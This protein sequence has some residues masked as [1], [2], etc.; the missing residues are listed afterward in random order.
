MVR[1]EREKLGPMVEIDESFIGGAEK[2]RPGRGARTKSQVLLAVELGSGKNKVGRIRLFVIPNAGSDSLLPFIVKNVEQGSKVVTDGWQGYASLTKE[3]FLHITKV[4]KKGQ[5]TLPHVHL[6]FSLL[7]R[8]LDGTF[9]GATRKCYLDFYL[10]EFVF[11]FNRRK[12]KSRGKLF[13]R[14]M[15]QAVMTP[16]VTRQELRVKTH[17]FADGKPFQKFCD[18]L[19]IA[20]A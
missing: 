6:V 18:A 9:Q 13:R 12:S 1:A 16:P 8:W 19:R 7:K 20:I 17:G 10:D 14:L 5:D 11:R 2:G 4:L 3:G 15:E